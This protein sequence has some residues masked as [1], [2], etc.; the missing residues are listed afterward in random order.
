[1]THLWSPSL[2]R[3]TES[4][5]SVGGPKSEPHLSLSLGRRDGVYY[6]DGL[7][8]EDSG[9]GQVLPPS[10]P[11]ILSVSLSLDSMHT[12]RHRQYNLILS[13]ILL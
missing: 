12:P 3:I 2:L 6:V 13:R 7:A 10:H 11:H 8:S 4:G 9:T 5:E 1:M